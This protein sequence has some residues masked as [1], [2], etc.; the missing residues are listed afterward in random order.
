VSP[1]K[2][3]PVAPPTVDAEWRI[4]FSTNNAIKGWQDLESQAAENLRRAWEIMR[5]NPG[6]GPG[7]PTD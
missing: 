5:N 6:P 2:G 7:K 3:D 4:R 1:K